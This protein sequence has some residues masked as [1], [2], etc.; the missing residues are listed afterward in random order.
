MA[1]SDDGVQ[2]DTN[3][4]VWTRRVQKIAVGLL[5]AGFQPGE[6]LAII[7][8]NS[9]DWLD[10]AFATWLVGGVLVPL[11][12]NWDRKVT[13]RCVARA[14][15]G[16]IAVEDETARLALRGQ[17]DKFPPIQWINL[18]GKGT[19]SSDVTTLDEIET[20]GRFRTQRGD[21][22]ALAKV[23]YGL[24]PEDPALIVYPHEEVEDPH[25]ATFSGGKLAIML[26]YLIDGLQLEDERVAV[27]L[28]YGWFHG[29]LSALAALF[30]G[31]TLAVA[32]SLSRLRGDVQ[33]LA[34]T[35]VVS[36]PAFVEGLATAFQDRLEAAPEFLK[37][38]QSGESFGFGSALS[39]LGEKAA[40][41]ILY[42]PLRS[43]LGGAIDRIYLVDGQVPDDVFDV[44]ENAKIHALG[45][46]GVPEA[47]ISHVERVGATRRNSVGR[48]LQ[49]YA[50]KVPGKDGVTAEVL[51][52][53]DVLFDK[54][55]DEKGPRQ[56]D[57]EGFLET[58]VEGRL[59][60][61][62]LFLAE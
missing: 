42:E 28:S 2:V 61:A 43:E 17:G 11:P 46:W 44:L 37:K 24:A 51:V 62:Y 21:L 26:E 18:T 5:D 20:Q 1:L 40:Q 53:S 47:G 7:S 57:D 35:V 56:I 60:S 55:W 12:S 4:W 8:P 49:G 29:L 23:T 54:Y 52:R 14:Q 9:Q 59:E 3:F 10:L 48:P 41:K 27:L 33:T 19:T 39:K 15:T 30:A 34:P 22:K 38:A 6:R 58:G 31:Q 16:W 25:G 45:M 36:G 50:C 32:S 13:L